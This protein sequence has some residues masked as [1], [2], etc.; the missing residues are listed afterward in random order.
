[1][2]LIVFEN[3]SRCS[4]LEETVRSRTR[5]RIDPLVS[6]QSNNVFSRDF[7]GISFSKLWQKSKTLKSQDLIAKLNSQLG[8]P[9]FRNISEAVLI[10]N[11]VSGQNSDLPIFTQHCYQTSHIE[12]TWEPS[13]GEQT[14]ENKAADQ[15]ASARSAE[16]TLFCTHLTPPHIQYGQTPRI[17]KDLSVNLYFRI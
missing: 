7:F 6:P 11:I 14:Q 1:M 15:A 16:V 4:L 13:T 12:A 5:W 17:Q 9:E 2:A 3:A 8:K 10:W